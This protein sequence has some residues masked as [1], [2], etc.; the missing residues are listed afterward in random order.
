[1]A[2]VATAAPTEAEGAGRWSRAL[3]TL[4]AG[5][6]VALYVFAVLGAPVTAHAPRPAL[7]EVAWLT[8]FLTF[9]LVGALIAWHRPRNAVGWLFLSVGV[10]NTG[11]S[12]IDEVA[13]QVL[14]THPA[15]S[16][17]AVLRL[18]QDLMFTLAWG[19]ATT[20]ALLLFPDG[21]LPSP[22]WRWVGYAAAVALAVAL[23][24]SAVAAGPIG[25]DAPVD[26]PFGLRGLGD[27]PLRVVDVAYWTLLG[28]A[29]ICLASFVVRWRRA[30]GVDRRRLA[31][32]ALAA[33]VVFAAVLVDVIARSVAPAWLLAALAAVQV[34]A[35][36]LAT[37]AAVLRERLF[38]VEVVLNR[39]L[40]YLILTGIVIA[41]YAGVLAVATG[42][43]GQDAAR[44]ASLLATAVVA[45]SLS[46][47]KERFQR[48]VDRLLF[49]DRSRPYAVLAGLAARLE[50]T[51]AL[52]E[53][54]RM[55]TSTVA[56]ALRL[57]YVEVTLNSADD[58]RTFAEAERIDLIAHGRAEGTLLAGRRPGE[59]AFTVR[60]RTL[61]DDLAR[62][63]A[64]AIRG[65]RLAEDLQASRERLVHARE[66]ER[67]R[68]RRDLHDGIGP[69]LAAVISKS[70]QCATGWTPPTPTCDNCWPK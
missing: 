40:V 64:L 22:R 47:V 44:G 51:T 67:L 12:V 23:L 66:D 6:A 69:T 31:W 41:T 16:I 46:P 52:D 49:G 56:D 59:H 63:V 28:L 61:L 37:A 13:Q 26:N 17:G 68:V 32:L 4:L 2:A 14:V 42:L 7:D 34:A 58:G 25:V 33:V 38:D 50:R 55:V 27:L 21:R 19:L 70:T 43:L 54:L 3:V 29:G 53:L 30:A 45:V 10:V 1:M 57:P 65:A 39:T 36:P 60:E 8:G 20:F 15:S 11:A 5:C 9:P 24:A 35:V 48:A 18:L 62:Q